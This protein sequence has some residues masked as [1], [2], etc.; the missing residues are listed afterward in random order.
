ME[1]I[2]ADRIR[3]FIQRTFEAMGSNSS[4]AALAAEVLISA[5]LRGIDSH[6]MSRLKGYIGLWKQGRINMNPQIK[7][8]R[9]KKSVFSVDGDSGLGLVVAPKVMDMVLERSTEYGSAWASISNSNHF[10]I[11]G[12]HAMK[13]LQHDNIGV[14]MTNATPFIPP[15]YSKEAML[16]TNPLAYAFPTNKYPPL[17]ID[18]ATASVARGKLEIAKRENKEIPKGWVVDKDGLPSTNVDELEQGGLL[19]PL[20]SLPELGSHKGYALGSLVDILTAVLSGASYGPW[21]PPF[22]SFLPLLPDQPGKGLGHFL[23]AMEVDGFREVGEF[24]SHMDHWI[25]TFKKAAPSGKEEVLVPGEPEY[26]SEIE[27]LEHGIPINEK[28]VQDLEEI[29]KEFKITLD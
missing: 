21:V 5:D 4:D 8:L 17:V 25:E 9:S 3:I 1:K 23:G 13:A 26:R 18:M 20:G 19:T 22:V 28:V 15:T 10:G 24:K 12:Y 11:A 2:K 27:R 7:I 14:A 16:G 29:A 6:G